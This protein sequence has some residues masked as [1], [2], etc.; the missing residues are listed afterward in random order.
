MV[1]YRGI[2][3][4][5]FELKSL[6][7]WAV[8]CS[9]CRTRQLRAHVV[10]RARDEQRETQTPEDAV[11]CH[12]D[13]LTWI[14]MGRR[15]GVT[16]SS[17]WLTLEDKARLG[18]DNHSAANGCLR[19]TEAEW[20]THGCRRCRYGS[21]SCR[22]SPPCLL[23]PRAPSNAPLAHAATPLLRVEALLRARR[24]PASAPYGAAVRVRPPPLRAA[25][26][27]KAGR[28]AAVRPLPP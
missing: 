8:P 17:A 25:P 9:P 23:L 27:H 11:P 2:P 7:P 28:P 26:R 3:T 12:M 15:L 16:R 13:I 20:T 19:T 5:W 24:A 18:P 14:R 21:T 1:G 22:S 4:V 6:C 10:R